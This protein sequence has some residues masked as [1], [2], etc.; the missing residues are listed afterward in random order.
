MGVYRRKR[1]EQDDP[2]L[3][4]YLATSKARGAK[5]T[6]LDSKD[7]VEFDSSLYEP[8]PDTHVDVPYQGLGVDEH[9]VFPPGYGPVPGETH[10]AKLWRKCKQ[11]PLV[12]L[13]RDFGLDC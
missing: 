6:D 7:N 4:Q 11:N 1:E 10:M 12:P 13:G 3:L 9:N 5:R 8:P 2:D